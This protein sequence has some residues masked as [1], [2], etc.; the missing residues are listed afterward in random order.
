MMHDDDGCLIGVLTLAGLCVALYL[1]AY[2][3]PWYDA[4]TKQLC[5]HASI[6]DS[7]II[8]MAVEKHP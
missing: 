2:A 8:C 7:S 1:L 6:A 3:I 5:W 4:K